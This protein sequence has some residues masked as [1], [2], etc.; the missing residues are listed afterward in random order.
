MSR[1]RVNFP[2]VVEVWPVE[3]A[4]KREQAKRMPVVPI[5]NIFCPFRFDRNRS[6]KVE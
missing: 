6:G 2:Y 1:E 5:L 4:A 3:E